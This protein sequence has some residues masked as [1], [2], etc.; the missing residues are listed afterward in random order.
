MGV[1]WAGR[2]VPRTPTAPSPTCVRQGNV[3]VRLGLRRL[4]LLMERPLPS[5]TNVRMSLSYPGLGYDSRDLYDKVTGEAERDGDRSAVIRLTAVGPADRD[6][7]PRGGRGRTQPTLVDVGSADA[8]SLRP[9]RPALS[10]PRRTDA[11]DRHDRRPGR[12]SADPCPS[13]AARC[14]GRIPGPLAPDCG[15]RR[16]AGTSRRDRLGGAAGPGRRGRLPCWC[17]MVPWRAPTL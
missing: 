15:K 12:D 3:G 8:P 16:A 14:A 2:P 13:R 10:A 11:A 6:G 5:L 17:L 1:G 4:D 7:F 9:G